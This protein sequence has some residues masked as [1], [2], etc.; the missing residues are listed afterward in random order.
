MLCAKTATGLGGGPF[1]NLV[2]PQGNVH[3]LEFLFREVGNRFDEPQAP[4]Q[5]T[6]SCLGERRGF[7]HEQASAGICPA[8]PP[9]RP[10]DHAA[11][12]KQHRGSGNSYLC[13]RSRSSRTHESPASPQSEP[14]P[15]PG[16]SV[17][18]ND[19]LLSELGEVPSQS[20]KGGGGM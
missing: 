17:A 11:E 9:R 1:W 10:C 19:A 15:S 16:Q 5:S 3:S 8:P 13:F 7:Q 12:K 2:G 4:R 20:G 18:V 14:G 6:L